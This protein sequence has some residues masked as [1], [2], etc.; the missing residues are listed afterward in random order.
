MKTS[1]QLTV[2][3]GRA[4]PPAGLSDG[5][6]R[7]K[8]MKSKISEIK[9]CI[10]G[11]VG[12]IETSEV[13]SFCKC[14]NCFPQTAHTLSCA[15]ATP[16]TLNLPQSGITESRCNPKSERALAHS[17]ARISSHHTPPA[18]ARALLSFVDRRQINTFIL[19]KRMN[20]LP[21]TCALSL[22]A[23]PAEPGHIFWSGEAW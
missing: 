1:A 23:G 7:E 18:L 4:A 20:S 22:S 19:I 17:L 12:N 15:C 6:E 21:H 5:A 11:S 2:P 8:E 9:S 16:A 14:L 13:Q 3:E 10:P